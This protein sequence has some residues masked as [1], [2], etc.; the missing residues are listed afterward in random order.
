[1]WKGVFKLSSKS[2]S[3][4]LKYFCP[5]LFLPTPRLTPTERGLEATYLMFRQCFHQLNSHNWPYFNPLSPFRK[6]LKTKPSCPDIS[7]ILKRAI[8]TSP[9][10]S[11]SPDTNCSLS[12]LLSPSSVFTALFRCLIQ[13]W[14]WSPGRG[15]TQS[16]DYNSQIIGICEY[17]S[18]MASNIALGF[19]K[20]ALHF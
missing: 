15:L 11:S 6:T 18:R 3:L 19:L 8:R 2:A 17:T 20:M 5:R 1:M 4:M 7:D 9:P 16:E 14:T 13:A 10:D 12:I